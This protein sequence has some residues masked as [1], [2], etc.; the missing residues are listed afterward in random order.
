MAEL[1]E[2]MKRPPNS[3]PRRKKKPQTQ[4]PFKPQ[5]EW[6]S[7]P[8]RACPPSLRGLKTERE[9]WSTDEKFYAEGMKGHGAAPKAR[10]GSSSKSKAPPSQAKVEQEYQEEY[11]KWMRRTGWNS[12]PFRNAPDPIKGLKPVTREPWY[13][14]MAIYNAKF[15][16]HIED[17]HE[18][19]NDESAL[20]A[21]Q[22]RK[23]TREEANW[24]SS[25]WKYVPHSLKGIKPVTNEPWARDESVY[26]ESRNS[27]DTRSSHE[28]MSMLTTNF[29][30]ED[31]GP[32]WDA[33]SKPPEGH[34][35][36]YPS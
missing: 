21:G 30:D 3:P 10:P 11:G 8:H 14:D 13:E 35:R 29:P 28:H 19:F 9:P 6:N 12:T 15:S 20:D 1:K 34:M 18:G 26:N 27:V 36:A 25:V 16:S 17:A 2:M 33:S 31:D 32:S 7:T 4:R 23:S 24:D 22:R 5:A